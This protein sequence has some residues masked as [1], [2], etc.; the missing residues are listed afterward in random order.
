MCDTTWLDVLQIRSG[1][2]TN[3]C[4][5][6][7]R[8]RTLTE[9]MIFGFH[10][11]KCEMSCYVEFEILEFTVRGL[12]RFTGGIVALKLAFNDFMSTDTALTCIKKVIAVET[13]HSYRDLRIFGEPRLLASSS[14]S[15]GLGQAGAPT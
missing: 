10:L 14:T 6:V 2:E 8:N 13:F 15:L 4:T 1:V 5:V 12:A 3:L 9:K 7:E 11:G